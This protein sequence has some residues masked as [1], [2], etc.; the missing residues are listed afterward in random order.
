MSHKRN[1]KGVPWIKS[2]FAFHYRLRR[3]MAAPMVA[4]A[5]VQ[6]H[7]QIN[8]IKCARTDWAPKVCAIARVQV[9]MFDAAKKASVLFLK[10]TDPGYIEGVSHG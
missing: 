2:P 6:G 1:W 7:A 3:A 9:E 4:G 5:I 10:P 8:A